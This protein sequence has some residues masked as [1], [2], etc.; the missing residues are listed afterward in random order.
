MTKK[1]KIT[2]EYTEKLIVVKKKKTWRAQRKTKN[3]AVSVVKEIWGR[4]RWVLCLL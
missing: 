3:S 2:A 4:E 1:Q